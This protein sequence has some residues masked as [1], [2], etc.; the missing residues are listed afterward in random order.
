MLSPN[1]LLRAE[2]GFADYG[3]YSF[4]MLAPT[5]DVFSAATSLETHTVSAGLAYKF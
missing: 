3:D 1:W 4:T 5:Q 2:I